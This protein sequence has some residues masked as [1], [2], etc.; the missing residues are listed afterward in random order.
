MTS[1]SLASGVL[2]YADDT[3]QT[4]NIYEQW[5]VGRILK[6]WDFSFL[7]KWEDEIRRMN[8]HKIGKPFRFP[9]SF[10]LFLALLKV[11]YHMPYRDIEAMVTGFRQLSKLIKVPDYTTVFKRVEKLIIQIHEKIPKEI[12]EEIK[13]GKAKVAID[14]SGLSVTCRG[15]WL[16]Y[17]HKEGKIFCKKGFVK[18]HIGVDVFR[19]T[20]LGVEITDEKASDSSA[21]PSIT[22]QAKE[23]AD[24]GAEFMDGAYDSYENFREL[25][26]MGIK[27]VI[28]PR[29]TGIVLSS[30]H[31]YVSGRRSRYIYEIKK[32]GYDYWRRKHNYG[33]RWLSEV[34]FSSFKRRFGESLMSKSFDNMAKEAKL[35]VIAYNMIT[36]WPRGW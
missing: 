15:E 12:L 32:H 31:G 1:S 2:T 35:K 22:Y 8:L 10:I 14:S 25:D 5:L 24:I 27:P 7:D 18:L 16:R 11:T 34:T 3:M 13:T 20:I 26:D 36:D 29:R 30:S 9:N 28:K 21:L 23:V 6:L 17:K 19:G 33:W 4:S